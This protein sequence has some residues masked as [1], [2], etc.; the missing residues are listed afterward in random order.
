MSR[1]V[2]FRFYMFRFDMLRVVPVRFCFVSHFPGTMS[3][4]IRIIIIH[5]Q[6]FNLQTSQTVTKQN[7]VIVKSKY[8]KKNTDRKETC[9][10]WK[11]TAS[12]DDLKRRWVHHRSCRKVFKLPALSKRIRSYA[13]MTI[14]GS[15]MY[16]LY[17]LMSSKHL[18]FYYSIYSFHKDI[19]TFIT[20]THVLFHKQRIIK[21]S[22]DV[23]YYESLLSSW[24]KIL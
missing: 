6:F 15:Y 14:N 3:K 11:I 16:M 7:G 9:D 21:S 19:V 20:T 10:R 4:S 2:S 12:Y 18:V 22:P 17:R 13:N 24:K 23:P 1:F 5:W 8:I